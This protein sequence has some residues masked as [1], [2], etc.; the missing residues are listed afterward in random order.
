MWLR[1]GACLWVQALPRTGY[2]SGYG[3]GQVG[4]ALV[5]AT[6]AMATIHFLQEM[7]FLL[8]LENHYQNILC[9]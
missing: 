7:L 3:Y 8:L 4:Q 6:V 2:G 9:R 1:L 5:L